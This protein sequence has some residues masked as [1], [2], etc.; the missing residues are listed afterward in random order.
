MVQRWPQDRSRSPTDRRQDA[1]RRLLDMPRKASNWSQHC[2]LLLSN[3][4][5]CFCSIF[6]Y[7][8]PLRDECE[9]P[10]HHIPTGHIFVQSDIL[11]AG[12]HSPISAPAGVLVPPVGEGEDGPGAWGRLL[13]FAGIAPCKPSFRALLD[14]AA[15]VVLGC[16]QNRACRLQPHPRGSCPPG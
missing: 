5:G 10:R 16:P 13:G 4:E 11:H 8:I 1:P 7:M 12:A 9:S 14:P 3:V 6:C 15:R 2:A